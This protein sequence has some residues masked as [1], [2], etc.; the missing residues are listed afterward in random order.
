MWLGAFRK[1]RRCAVSEPGAMKQFAGSTVE[2]QRKV[3]SAKVNEPR[4]IRS[5]LLE[6]LFT[7]LIFVLPNG[8][9][10]RR[11]FESAFL[12]INRKE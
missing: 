12:R 1:A 3:K 5:L 4:N 9:Y 2:L 7:Y 11:C 6:C 8:R 10:R